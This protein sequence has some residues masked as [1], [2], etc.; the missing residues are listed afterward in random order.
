MFQQT[1]NN[2]L[3]TYFEKAYYSHIVGMRKPNAEIYNFVINDAKINPE[4]TLFIDDT[5]LNVIAA[6]KLGFQT[7]LLLS[8]EK[9]EDLVYFK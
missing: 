3:D 7:H 2:Q 9:I 1:G 6:Q 5:Q 8:D 4:E